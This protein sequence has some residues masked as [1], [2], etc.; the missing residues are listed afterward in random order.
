MPPHRRKS[1]EEL[2]DALSSTHHSLYAVQEE[3]E[4]LSEATSATHREPSQ[5]LT[6]EEEEEKE[7]V[8]TSPPT[9]TPTPADDELKKES[10]EVDISLRIHEKVASISSKAYRKA[11]AK[12]NVLF[13]DKV[14][15]V[16]L[17]KFNDLTVG[18]LLGK[19]SFSY[20][21][22]IT[23]I[24][25]A[26]PS[27]NNETQ[28][29]DDN[30]NGS[31]ENKDSS[32]QG[33]DDRD[34]TIKHANNNNNKEEENNASFLVSNYERPESKTYRYAVKFLKDDIR[35][36]PKSYAIGT[37]DLVV[38]GMF[39]ASLT[40]PNIIKVRALPE[41]GVRSLVQPNATKG[42]FLVLD[43]LFDTLS[44]RI[45]N[46]WQEQHHVAMAGSGCLSCLL[47]SF[48]KK[49]TQALEEE[50]KCLGERLKVAYDISAALK[51]LHSK[52]IIYR[53]LKPEN[54]GFDSEFCV[55][56]AFFIS[57]SFLKTSFLAVDTLILTPY[58]CPSIPYSTR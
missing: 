1:V 44:E 38:E 17:V 28:H 57:L 48:A 9:S 18:Q 24:S 25:T 51:F 53:D 23:K 54:L 7:P 58:R 11:S 8:V 47:P 26:P 45:Y 49:H 13:T 30:D 10:D 21:H 2:Q 22:E 41:G 19:G 16:A 34:P 27:S 4:D 43:R 14:A 39:L 20:V 50:K 40:H 12:S 31:G 35:S 46:K 52:S 32:Q 3:M 42:Y 15:G 56:C 36:N 37:V 55:M 5:L 33:G 6:E 29:H